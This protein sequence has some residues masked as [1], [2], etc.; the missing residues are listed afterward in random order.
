MLLFWVSILSL[1]F[2]CYKQVL[3][4]DG[5]NRLIKFKYITLKLKK[6]AN[7]RYRN[8]SGLT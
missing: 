7:W 6:Y 5:N 4:L 1:T 2:F 3:S 8:Y